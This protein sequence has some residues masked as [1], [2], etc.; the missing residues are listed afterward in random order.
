MLRSM[1]GFGSATCTEGGLTVGVEIRSVNNRHRKCLVRL[2]EEIMA[3]EGPLERIV[4]EH[5]QRGSL[6][7]SVRVQETSDDRAGRIDKTAFQSY[8]NQI[9]GMSGVDHSATKIDLSG[10]LNLPG[11]I[12]FDEEQ[13]LHRVGALAKQAALESCVQLQ[14]MRE[15]EGQALEH[16]LSTQCAVIEERLKTIRSAIPSIT[17]QHEERMLQRMREMLESLNVAEDPKDLVREVA[18]FAERSDISEE[19]T[20]MDAHLLQFRELLIGKEPI[21]RTLDFLTQEML[22][23]TNTI[24]SKVQQ[25]DVSRAIVEIK[26]AVDRLKEQ[27]QNVE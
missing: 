25:V 1:T 2:P 20:R 3:L 24:G 18:F 12:V 7:I 8:L 17:K 26:S 10:I 4:V 23:E 21:G 19:V 9:L 6:T 11:V 14:R 13:R 5:F 27:V 22:R 15:H 16:D